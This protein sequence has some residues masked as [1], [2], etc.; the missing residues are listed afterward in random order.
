D[1]AARSRGCPQG[2][3]AEGLPV[4]GREGRARAIALDERARRVRS[5]GKI[6]WGAARS[7]ACRATAPLLLYHVLGRAG[8][9][10]SGGCCLAGNP[11]VARTAP[12]YSGDRPRVKPVPG[13]LDALQH[14]IDKG[15]PLAAKRAPQGGERTPFG[16]FSAAPAPPP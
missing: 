8:G 6:I 16:A 5:P 1:G 7:A 9:G 15:H 12:Y 3:G 2:A 11:S 14:P 4:G 10:L 13:S